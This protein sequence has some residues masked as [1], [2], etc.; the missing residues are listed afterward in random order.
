M[1]LIGIN[2]STHPGIHDPRK[3]DI[4]VQD[5]KWWGL[6]QGGADPRIST[7][8]HGQ[9]PQGIQSASTGPVPWVT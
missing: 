1:K 9:E 6:G 7:P 3:S 2:V 8:G 5:T 4:L